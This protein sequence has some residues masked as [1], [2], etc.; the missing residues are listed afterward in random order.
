[1]IEKNFTIS[2][3]IPTFNDSEQLKEL[4]NHLLK[5]SI[6]PNEII[7]IDSS[8]NDLIKKLVN[9]FNFHKIKFIY[10]KI[11]PSFAGKSINIGSNLS[12]CKYIAFL[13]T[14]T[15]PDNNWIEYYMNVIIEKKINLLFGSTKYISMNYYQ[16]LLRASSY[17]SIGHETVPGT[18][19][20]KSLFL[21]EKGFNENVRSGYDIEWRNRIKSKSNWSSPVKSLIKYKYLPNNIY[22]TSLKYSY[23]SLNTAII[24]IQTSLKDCYFSLFLIFSALIIPKWNT[25]LVGWDNH[26]FYIHNITKIYLICLILILIIFQ[27]VKNISIYK[28]NSFFE[29]ILKFILFIFLT[30]SVYNWNQI[31]AGWIVESILYI[32]H[33]T[34]IYLSLLIIISIIYRGLILPIKRKVEFKFLFPFNWILVGFLGLF[35]DLTKAPFYV[36]GAILSPFLQRKI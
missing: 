13:D 35:I 11:L 34:K 18:I 9:E 28:N 31:V 2:I 32:P 10:K 30:Y 5:Q 21:S 26:P 22:E 20:E 4:L 17:G 7:I 33:I 12:E 6:K 15:I 1:M 25:F 16:H 3:L 14:K 19:I 29:N 36:I 27:I 24:N 8:N 23:Y